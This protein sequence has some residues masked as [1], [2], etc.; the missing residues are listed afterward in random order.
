MSS[1][2]KTIERMKNLEAE[3]KNLMH[4]FEKLN[5]MAD[6]KAA[7]LEYEIASLR[8]EIES[9][10][11]LMAEERKQ[12]PSGKVPQ[13]PK[14]SSKEI[15]E[16]TIGESNS[17]GNQVFPLPPFGQYFDNWLV[18]LR[19]LVS[20]FESNST[21]EVDEQFGKDRSQILL[22]VE[23]ALARIRMEESNL[24]Q[25]EK[26]LAENNRLLEEAD[27]EYAE[28]TKAISSKRDSEVERLTKKMR[29]LESEIANQEKLNQEKPK[30]GIFSYRSRKEYNMAKDKAAEDLNH[31]K[32]DLK[33]TT[34]ELETSVK[35]FSVDQTNLDNEYE[36]RKQGI[37]E[38]AESLRGELKKLETDTSIEARQAASNALANAIN[39]L[40]QRTHQTLE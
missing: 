3:K 39:A 6:L 2:R 17:L 36:K 40:I 33:A 34:N 18:N 37:T 38:R 14:V 22:D 26:A 27:E 5:E 9:V 8:E 29:E 30:I 23:S 15:V 31:N 35:G 28:K 13:V 10:K 21:I 32:E 16:K 1:L 12:Q 24:I 20:E 7:S 19:Q 25:D 4:E 11:M